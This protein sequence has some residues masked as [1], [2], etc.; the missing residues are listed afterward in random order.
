MTT[1]GETHGQ[2]DESQDVN[3]YALCP[4]SPSRF[5]VIVI[6]LSIYMYIYTLTIGGGYS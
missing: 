2:R 1:P 4:H 3:V 6:D 5:W